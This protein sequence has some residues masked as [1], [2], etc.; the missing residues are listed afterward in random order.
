[1]IIFGNGA[2]FGRVRTD[3]AGNALATPTPTRF[4]VI[5]D[6]SFDISREL[7]ML[8]GERS[9]PVAVGAGKAKASFKAKLGNFSADVYGKLYGGRT[10]LTTPRL[11]QVDDPITIAA[12]VTTTPPSSG[13]FL[14]DYGIVDVS[15][16]NPYRRVASAP[17]LGEYSL[18]GSTYTFNA[19]DVGKAALRNYEYSVAA[20]PGNSLFSLNNEIMGQAPSFTYIGQTLYQ[21]KRL[22]L[23]LENCISAKFSL[24]QKNDDFAVQDFEFEAFDNGSGSLGYMMITEPS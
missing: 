5:Q 15:T 21:G 18:S 2:A 8:Y 13:T 23:Q 6:L 4:G 7:K 12:S 24:P 1:M 11:M 19:S 17:A 10:A 9:Y 16:G 3:F 20:T 14:T 22:V